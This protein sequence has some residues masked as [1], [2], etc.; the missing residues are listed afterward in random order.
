MLTRDPKTGQVMRDSHA[1]IADQ[2][3]GLGRRKKGRGGGGITKLLSRKRKHSRAGRLVT[4]APLPQYAP[5]PQ[6][7]EPEEY[8]AEE[9]VSYQ[10]EPEYEAP[11][12]QEEVQQPAPEPAYVPSEDYDGPSDEAIQT[13]GCCGGYLISHATEPDIYPYENPKTWSGLLR[14]TRRNEVLG[15]G[16]DAR[17]KNRPPKRP[18]TYAQA[19]RTRRMPPGMGYHREDGYLPFESRGM[20]QVTDAA[21]TEALRTYPLIFKAVSADMDY[22]SNT[23]PADWDERVNQAGD[24]FRVQYDA[25]K[26]LV[27][28]RTGNPEAE[29][30]L[31]HLLVGLN[32][33]V[34]EMRQ[35]APSWLAKGADAFARFFGDFVRG[36]REAVD[37][38]MAWAKA[39]AMEALKKYH[40]ARVRIVELKND[41][42]RARAAGTVTGAQAALQEVKIAGAETALNTASGSLPFLGSPLDSFAEEQ[43]GKYPQLG[44]EPLSA[45]II[46]AIAVGAAII[47]V[48]AAIVFAIVFL[49]VKAPAL[50]ATG[51][52][53]I[54]VLAVFMALK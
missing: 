46:I 2:L 41:L 38:Y 43:F 25:Y 20:G 34:F 11:P 36:A 13:E 49:S 42:R 22:L 10:R 30:K 19:L 33:K 9:P 50:M 6:Y 51:L 53:A 44:A 48:A 45:S 47:L 5:P 14:E 1:E 31:R 4:R 26:K 28:D 27:H 29:M 32:S 12:A 52:I 37:S 39:K 21:R 35:N 24:T 8:S 16:K 18:P 40:G 3:F 7:A 15:R 17:F 54:G 23:R